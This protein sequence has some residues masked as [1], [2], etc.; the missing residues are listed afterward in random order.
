MIRKA[1]IM[2]VNPDQHAEY[3]KRHNPIWP[4][5]EAILKANGAHNYSIFLDPGTSRLFGY[6]EI[7]D[8]R[9]WADIAKT[10][11]CKKWWAHMQPIMPCHSDNSPI[12]KDLEQVFHMG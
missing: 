1:F 7:E 2:Q 6:V 10:D 9:R 5:L 12:S 4:E 3:I 8:E 11:V